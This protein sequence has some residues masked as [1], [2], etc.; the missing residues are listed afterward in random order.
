MFPATYYFKNRELNE[1][2]V[3]GMS[4]SLPNTPYFGALAMGT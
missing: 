2:P 3:D 4:T 1:M